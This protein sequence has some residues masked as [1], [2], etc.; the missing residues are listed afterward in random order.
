MRTRCPCCASVFLARH[1]SNMTR[2]L[3]VNTVFSSSASAREAVLSRLAASG[4][5]KDALPVHCRIRLEAPR[6]HPSVLYPLKP[7]FRTSSLRLYA[8]VRQQPTESACSHPCSSMPYEY[9][10]Q[11]TGIMNGRGHSQK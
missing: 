8:A 1:S 11:H 6:T 5:G 10:V 7:R 9:T 3:Y 2:P 4:K